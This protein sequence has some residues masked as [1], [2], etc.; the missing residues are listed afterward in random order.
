[1]N[2]VKNNTMENATSVLNQ[3]IEILKAGK[4]GYKENVIA[5]INLAKEL[6]E[7]AIEENKPKVNPETEER[8]KLQELCKTLKKWAEDGGIK[9]GINQL[10]YGYYTDH[11][12]DRLATEDSWEAKGGKVHDDAQAYLFWGAKETRYTRDGR[13]YDY[14]NVEKRYDIKDVTFIDDDIAPNEADDMVQ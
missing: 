8:K 7:K 12:A 13:K 10:L 4:K 5:Q 9:M 6:F 3:A 11:G 2:N 14:Y 1:M